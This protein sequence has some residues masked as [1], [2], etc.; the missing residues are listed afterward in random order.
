MTA[1][2]YTFCKEIYSSVKIKKSLKQSLQNQAFYNF[3]LMV[4]VLCS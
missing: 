3:Q 2:Y 1:F 4:K